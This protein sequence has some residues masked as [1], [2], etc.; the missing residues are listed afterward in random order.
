MF[1]VK[2]ARKAMDTTPVLPPA[3]MDF[4]AF[5]AQ[6]D[7]E[8]RMRHVVIAD[9]E[10]IIG[11]LRVNTALRHASEDAPSGIT[12]RELASN[13]VIVHETTSSLMS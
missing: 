12:L 6:P 7:H 8:G 2:R 10:R 13:F 11:V 1:L 5:L 4:G 9:G 3:D